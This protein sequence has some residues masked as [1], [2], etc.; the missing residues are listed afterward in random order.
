MKLKKRM[1]RIIAIVLVCILAVNITGCKKRTDDNGQEKKTSQN[2]PKP[3]EKAASATE[4]PAT[5]TVVDITP[6][7]VPTNA[8]TITLTAVPTMTPAATD[9]PTPVPDTSDYL[10]INSTITAV[11]DR[12]Y[13]YYGKIG[14][15]TGEWRGDRPEGTGR[16]IIGTEEY[17]DGQWD[18]GYICGNA[19]ILI[20]QENGSEFAYVGDCRGD[21]IYGE[22]QLYF[23]PDKTSQGCVF[24]SGDFRNE[25]SLLY[26]TYDDEGFLEDIG[27]MAD[28]DMI[29]YLDN[30]DLVN[31]QTKA[32]VISRVQDMYFLPGNNYPFR[33]GS[34]LTAEGTYTGSIND[35]GVP[36]G[37]GMFVKTNSIIDEEYPILVDGVQMNV[38]WRKY[39][40]YLGLWQNGVL[41]G[42]YIIL[43]REEPTDLQYY[44]YEHISHKQ[45]VYRS[46]DKIEK[47]RTYIDTFITNVVTKEMQDTLEVIEEDYLEPELY[48]DN[49]DGYRNE[50]EVYRSNRILYQTQFR[51]AGQVWYTIYPA[52]TICQTEVY[53]THSV[54]P[55]N[56]L[57]NNYTEDSYY[58][59]GYQAFYN[60]KEELIKYIKYDWN[61][62]EGQ[63]IKEEPKLGWGKIILGAA[64]VFLGGVIVYKL[65]ATS[66]KGTTSNAADK[67]LEEQRRQIKADQDQYNERKKQADELARRIASLES[68]LSSALY[69]SEARIAEIKREIAELRA[70]ESRIRPS[71]F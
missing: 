43:Y 64:A 27:F 29:S 56:S 54:T 53:K 21:R 52:G 24:I 69:L 41:T 59:D 38:K 3:T 14:S 6:T 71:I 44:D 4:V 20:P 36:N 39:R 1:T 62:P 22:G 23:W 8:P 10:Y 46:G 67:W 31:Y 45:Y 30:I 12:P 40:A 51:H 5:P 68:E 35:A 49:C 2:Q 17:Y 65:L 42:N 60:D 33:P 11:K 48:D 50:K 55:P 70:E 58:F 18:Y 25:K 66:S 57:R 63:E 28:G 9:T 13:T 26:L 47:T 37:Y 16:L 15:Y 7:V 32:T 61:K 34:E 19:K